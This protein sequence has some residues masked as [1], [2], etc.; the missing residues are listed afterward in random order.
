MAG[1][2]EVGRVADLNSSLPLAQPEPESSIHAEVI[3]L[4]RESG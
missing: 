2:G 4:S 3:E 1:T